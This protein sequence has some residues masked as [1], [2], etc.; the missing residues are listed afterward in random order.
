[1]KKNL[2]QKLAMISILLTLTGGVMAK[3]PEKTVTLIDKSKPTAVIYINWSPEKAKELALTK[4]NISITN[5]YLNK[6]RLRMIED[7][8]YHLNKMS[9]TE[10]KVIVTDSPEK[11]IT[12]ALVLGELAVKMGAVPKG[13]TETKESF[14]LICKDGLIL[15]GGESDIGAMYGVYELLE[16]LGCDWI[17]PGEAGEVIPHMKT[18][19][20]SFMD[21]AQTPDFEIRAPWYTTPPVTKQ[22]LKEFDVW[23]MRKKNQTT[24][25]LHPLKMIGGHVWD[26]LTKKY[27]KEF[28][29]NPEMLALVRKPDGTLKR[30]GP[31]IETT[32]SKT[33]DLF[34]H[35]IEEKFKKNKWPKNKKVCLGVGP[36]DGMGY[37]ESPESLVAGADRYDP[38]NGLPD[39]TDLQILLCNQLLERLGKE[40][41]NLYLG[42]YLYSVHADYPMLYKPHPHVMIVIAEIS[43]SRFHAT[44]DHNSKSRAYYQT[45]LK[46]W[47][48]LHQEQGNPIMYRGYNWNLAENLLP[49]TKLKM[50]GEDLPYYKKMGCSGSYVQWFKNWSNTGPSD[51]LEAEMNWNTNLKWRDVLKKYCKHAFGKG[52]PFMERYYLKLVKRQH[53][54]GMEAGS[55]HAFHLIYDDQFIAESNKLFEQAIAAADTDQ[56]KR[57][58]RW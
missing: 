15:I 12:P 2:S 40:Y 28:E 11:I 48:R 27:K 5:R 54:S 39:M 26:I 22:E 13:K 41:P 10:L 57:M 34:V 7:L 17:M 9:G 33:L 56:N 24:R 32:N 55:Y 35:Y 50:W 44:S 3:N 38:V 14:R 25:N 19:T 52:G 45:I 46:Q 51:Y 37:S 42:F 1:M 21:E 6:C 18:V 53:G 49:Y 58:I 30:Q 29:K 23:K 31:Q 20:V 16:K 36:A 43:Y 47:K 4:K 8:N